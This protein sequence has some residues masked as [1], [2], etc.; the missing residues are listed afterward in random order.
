MAPGE[1]KF[2]REIAKTDFS[3]QRSEDRDISQQGHRDQT[4]E[5]GGNRSR[6]TTDGPVSFKGIPLAEVAKGGEGAKSAY[7]RLK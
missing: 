7:L 2:H 5:K 6:K 3:Q 4:F 1:N